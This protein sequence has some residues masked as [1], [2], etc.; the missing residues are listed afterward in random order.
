MRGERGARQLGKRSALGLFSGKRASVVSIDAQRRWIL[1]PRFTYFSGAA[2]T[3][4]T[5]DSLTHALPVRFG[6]ETDFAL[7]RHVPRITLPS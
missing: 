7:L 6:V 4:A 5:R 2:I 3:T 1:Y